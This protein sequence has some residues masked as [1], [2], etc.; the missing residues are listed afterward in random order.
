MLPLGTRA[1]NP[2]GPT[3]EEVENTK[4]PS[5]S[6]GMMV[7]AATPASAPLLLGSC[8]LPVWKTAPSRGL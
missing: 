2:A 3:V 7:N 5:V 8:I 6:L 4:S 1:Y